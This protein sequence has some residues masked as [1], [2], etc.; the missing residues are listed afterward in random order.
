MLNIP[1]MKSA[2]CQMTVSGVVKE[3]GAEVISIASTKVELSLKDGI[4]KQAVI[5]AIENA[6]YAVSR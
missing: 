3:L 1:A 2:H 4:S 5:I 6:G